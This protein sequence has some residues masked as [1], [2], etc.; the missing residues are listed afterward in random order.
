MEQYTITADMLEGIIKN[1]Y[2]VG[3]QSGILTSSLKSTESWI[4]ADR[5]SVIDQTFSS[6]EK[7]DR[8]VKEFSKKLEEYKLWV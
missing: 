1:A 7:H 2:N 3:Y 4:E 5:N 6:V 8:E